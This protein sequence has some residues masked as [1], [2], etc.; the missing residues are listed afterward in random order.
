MTCSTG[1]IF[2]AGIAV[3]V[4]AERHVQRLH[5][6]HLHHLV[7]PAMAAY[8][9]HTG[10]HVRLVVEEHEIGEPVNANP[11]DGF[12]GVVAVANFFEPGALRLHPRVA[13]HADFGLRNRRV[14]GLVRGV[15]AVVAIHAEIAGM[16]FV[17]VRDGLRRLIAGHDHR[18]G[19]RYTSPDAPPPTADASHGQAPILTYLS[20]DFGKMSAIEIET[21]RCERPER[22]NF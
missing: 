13:V 16:Q 20:V 11:L 6:L 10:G 12:A 9:T 7:D 3:A 2:G 18:A 14:T 4:E 17:T 19:N 8:A 1:R 5:L 15:V 22:T 21:E